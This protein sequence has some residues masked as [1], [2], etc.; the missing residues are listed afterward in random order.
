MSLIHRR[1]L[2]ALL[3]VCSAT[4]V[5]PAEQQRAIRAAVALALAMEPGSAVSGVPFA[6]QPVVEI[7]DSSNT[8]VAESAADV[9]A[10]IAFG[11]GVLSG[12]TTVKAVNGVATFTDLTVDGIGTQIMTFSADG[13]NGATSTAFTVGLSPTTPRIPT[14]LTLQTQPAGAVTG[15]PF[16]IQPVVHILDQAGVVIDTGVNSVLAVTATRT[17]GSGTLSGTTTVNAAAGVAAFTDL[18]IDGTGQQVLTF[19]IA[20]PTLQVQSNAVN[21]TAVPAGPAAQLAI[22]AQP[23]NATSGVN[24]ASAPV[25]ELRDAAGALSTSNAT[26]TATIASGTGTLAGITT[27]TGMRSSRP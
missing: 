20:S 6:V 10:S 17:S 11:S 5:N 8:L 26:V 19:S 2:L 22:V 4:C 13:L 9:T 16:S 1:S 21:V 15:L 27:V 23:S 18:Q 25:V 24:F 14:A 3:V 7:R 12:T